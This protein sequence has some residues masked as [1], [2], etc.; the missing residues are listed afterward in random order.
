MKNATP[1]D[2]DLHRLGER[3]HFDELQK[4]AGIFPPDES[5]ER[6]PHALAVD[7]LPAVP[8]GAGHVHDHD[9]GALGVVARVMD[10]DVIGMKSDGA[11]K[12]RSDGGRASVFCIF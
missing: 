5:I 4:I 12:R 6:K 8:H 11:T 3:V 2:T 10:F 1:D 7:V 9:G